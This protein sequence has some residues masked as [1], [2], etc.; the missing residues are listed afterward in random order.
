MAQPL[1]VVACSTSALLSLMHGLIF[2]RLFA[3]HPLIQPSF[4]WLI[5]L[6]E[7]NF[8]HKKVLSVQ[9]VS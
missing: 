1:L 9:M 7:F 4:E 8:P 3:N 5:Y 6:F 2:L